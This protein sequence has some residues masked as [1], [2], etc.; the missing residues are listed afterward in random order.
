MQLIEQNDN[1][2]LGLKHFYSFIKQKF[3]KILTDD[4]Y[5]IQFR[6]VLF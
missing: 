2:Y 4:S 6:F 1:N 5:P 3:K